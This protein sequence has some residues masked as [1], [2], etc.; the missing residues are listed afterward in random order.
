MKEK[1]PKPGTK[2]MIRVPENKRDG[3]PWSYFTDAT[4]WEIKLKNKIIISLGFSVHNV[5]NRKHKVSQIEK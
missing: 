4:G 5:K 2:L 1:A 3:K